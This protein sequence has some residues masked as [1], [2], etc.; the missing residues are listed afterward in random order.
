MLLLVFITF[1]YNHGV[2]NP[3]VGLHFMRTSNTVAFSGKRSAG[4]TL[5]E[6]IA[7]I[8][9]LGILAVSAAP[10]FIDLQKDARVSVLKGIQGSVKSV[11]NMVY[12]KAMFNGA[13]TSYSEVGTTNIWVS[14][15]SKNNC[16]E[17]EG[18]NVYFKHAYLDRNSV[19]FALNG[20]IGGRK[21][22]KI[23]NS[24]TGKKISIPD[25]CGNGSV[26]QKNGGSCGTAEKNSINYECNKYGANDVCTEYD[27][28]VCRY[29]NGSK[30]SERFIPK[31]IR[32]KNGN[33]YLQ[34]TTA[35]NSHGAVPLYSIVS[36]GC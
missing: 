20:N 19:V 22:V 1:K 29:R 24:A 12:A 14:D 9:I 31:G 25:R 17:V 11:N 36:S 27:I 35:E 5:I 18:V 13:N 28:C 4:F 8:V 23:Q 30:D 6:L 15:C 3:K 7:V 10:K 2:R 16:V 26:P 33:C 21:T 34:Y 32:Y